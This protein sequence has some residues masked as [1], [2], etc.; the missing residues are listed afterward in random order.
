MEVHSIAS[1]GF[2]PE[3][4]NLSLT[5]KQ[6]TERDLADNSKDAASQ[7]PTMGNSCRKD[8]SVGFF[9]CLFF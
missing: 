7:L 8:D 4:A 5:G 2:L 9:V 1:E 3:K 6:S